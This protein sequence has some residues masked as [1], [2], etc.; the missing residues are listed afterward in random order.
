MPA[1]C[2][3]NHTLEVVVKVVDGRRESIHKNEHE[4]SFADAVVAMQHLKKGGMQHL[5]KGGMQ[6]LKGEGCNT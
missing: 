2:P 3:P 6:H 5:K 4:C 1:D